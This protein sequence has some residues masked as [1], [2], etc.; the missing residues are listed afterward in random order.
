MEEVD[1]KNQSTP[2]GDQS[3]DSKT[4]KEQKS[5]FRSTLAISLVVGVVVAG[6]V[7]FAVLKH[8]QTNSTTV[9]S[10][11]TAGIKLGNANDTT[12]SEA[13]DTS[14]EEPEDGFYQT[15]AQ[16]NDYQADATIQL[17]ASGPSPQ[18]MTVP[19]GTKVIWQNIDTANH[20]IAIS[21][22]QTVPPQFY[23]NRTIVA[24]DGYP[25]VVS[26]TGT[27]DYYFVDNPSLTGQLIVK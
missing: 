4:S 5:N 16:L 12:T 10:V 23:N 6:G 21:P 22:G 18:T 13:A 26:Q 25:Y 24:G 9:A 2:N 8:D 3:S 11:S 1:P 7:I 17:T 20:E 19:V 14:G 15:E 27:F